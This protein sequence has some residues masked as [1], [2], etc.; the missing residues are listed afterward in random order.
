MRKKNVF[1]CFSFVLLISILG[2]NFYPQSATAIDIYDNK[3]RYRM[4]PNEYI[5]FN[6]RNLRNYF[7]IYSNVF[8]DLYLEYNFSIN[9]RQLFLTVQNSEPISLNITCQ[10]NLRNF[11]KELPENPTLEDII[12]TFTYNSVYRIYS[13]T[14]I[15]KVILRFSKQLMFGL[16][17]NFNFSL[18][19]Y[20]EGED[21][22]IP[23]K[24]VEKFDNLTKI[25]YIEGNLSN[26]EGDTAYYFTIYDIEEQVNP[27]PVDL[28][29]IL[30]LLIIGGLG[31]I[32]L[33]VVVSKQD[34]IDYLKRKFT[35]IE[36]G[37]HRLTIEE[38]LEN[39]NRSKIIDLILEYP[40]IHFNELLRKTNLSPG[41]LAWHL[42]LLETYKIIRKE[43]F[44]H[45]LVY[46]PY[47]QKNP[48][49]NIDLTLKKSD[50]TLK[51]LEIIQE[52]PGIW[53]SMITKKL[54]IN[55]KTIQY[56]IEKLVE[57]GLIQAKKEGTRKK[58]F[59]NLDSDY[60]K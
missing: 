52:N 11:L 46:F 49:S 59:P 1:R 25:P 30:Y 4:N 7:F 47:Y 8:I 60:F 51:V 42:D 36:K 58:L 41:N 5:Q 38:I 56:H 54:K 35:S 43:R 13:N 33:V 37:A 2:L 28:S 57:L 32:I 15:E 16:N 9:N 45:Y 20:K 10:F 26:I 50:L 19:Y 34:Y 44:E 21:S 40:G 29:L 27:P 53:N 23:L 55:R 48:I 14:T 24:T 31:I 22:W 39:E 3:I 6:F 17:P 18:A 12:L